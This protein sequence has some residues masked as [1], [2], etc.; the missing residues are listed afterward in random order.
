MLIFVY[1]YTYIYIDAD[2]DCDNGLISDN[3]D[4][5]CPTLCGECGGNDCDSIFGTDSD[6]LCCTEDIT[7][8][9]LS[10]RDNSAPCVL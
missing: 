2:P 10:C 7:E 4:V 6:Y 3:D 8:A 9:A 1:I 5:C